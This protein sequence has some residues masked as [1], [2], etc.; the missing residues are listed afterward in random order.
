MVFTIDPPTSTDL[1]DA[2]SIESLGDN[3]FEVG[4]HIADVSSF[5]SN[6]NRDEI[7]KRTT[8]VYLP[9]KVYHMLPA[10]LV[11][12]CSLDPG[13]ERL[14][15]TVWVVIDINGNVI[16][17]GRLEKNIIKSRFKLSYEIVQNLITSKLD[18]EGFNAKYPCSKIEFDDLLEKLLNL[19]T[20]ATGHRNQRIL[21]DVFENREMTF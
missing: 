7:V 14:A 3:L 20:I 18:Y 10:G 17:E 6:I 5:L 12:V 16:G 1:D 11:G 19:T 2:L 9:N 8:S 4:I 15:F 13:V 21:F